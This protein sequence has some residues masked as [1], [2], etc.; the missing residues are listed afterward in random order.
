[1]KS[2]ALALVLA[3]AASGTYAAPAANDGLVLVGT[4]SLGANGTLTYWGAA[5]DA[6]SPAL[7]ARAVVDA[8]ACGTNNV[9]CF[10]S[11]QANSAT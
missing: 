3:T 2:S 8:R 4:K 11:H 5:D 10:S 9:Q 1:M 7:S 6:A